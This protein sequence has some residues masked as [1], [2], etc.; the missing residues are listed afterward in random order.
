MPSLL[1]PMS[2]AAIT[3]N[4]QHQSSSNML[5]QWRNHFEGSTTPPTQQSGATTASLGKLETS[6]LSSSTH[7]SG[8][9]SP[10]IHAANGQSHP[11]VPNMDALGIFRGLQDRAIVVDQMHY[12]TALAAT[13]AA[14]ASNG[15]PKSI[16]PSALPNG[17]HLSGDYTTR[18]SRDLQTRGTLGALPSASGLHQQPPPQPP[19]P[20]YFRMNT[21]LNAFMK[22][23]QEEEAEI[24]KHDC[25]KA[26]LAEPE[27][28]R[29]F[30]KMT[31]EMVITKSGR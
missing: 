27:L 13:L 4:Q 9:V 10:H 17:M 20:T 6:S 19:P 23:V 2:A 31:T 11:V 16:P 15:L 29:A 22:R 24:K 28:W 8:T 30:H 14:V 3:V 12:A 21:E 18:S 5:P 1:T 26:E 25:P 7:S